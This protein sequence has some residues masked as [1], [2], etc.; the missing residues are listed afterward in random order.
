MFVCFKI[1]LPYFNHIII[2]LTNFY[3]FWGGFKTIDSELIRRFVPES[4]KEIKEV[5][6]SSY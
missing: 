4:G 5:N 2:F 1:E 6:L 3:A